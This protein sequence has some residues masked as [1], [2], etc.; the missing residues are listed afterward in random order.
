MKAYGVIYTATRATASLV[1]PKLNCVN[2]FS[3]FENG[4]THHCYFKYNHTHSAQANSITYHYTSSEPCSILDFHVVNHR[5]SSPLAILNNGG[6]CLDA[7]VDIE[8]FDSIA[9]S[10]TFPLEC[11]RLCMYPWMI[12]AV[13]AIFG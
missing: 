6:E 13:G 7:I 5:A 1:V 10:S 2:H 3:R 8:Q 9:E 11:V 4:K 12:Q